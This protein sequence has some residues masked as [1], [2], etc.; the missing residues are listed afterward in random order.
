MPR[1]IEIADQIDIETKAL[2]QEKIKLE[3]DL[4]QK[5]DKLKTLIQEN[6]NFEE[7]VR[8]KDQT[9]NELTDKN[10][11]LELIHKIDPVQK[12]DGWNIVKGKDGYYRAN[13]KIKGKVVSVHIGRQFNIHKA[14]NKIQVKLRKLMIN[15]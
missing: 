9:I 14:K 2:S 7:A 6:I 12:V 15:Q 4:K 10:K 11:E 8:E 1:L 13:R 3:K 5:D